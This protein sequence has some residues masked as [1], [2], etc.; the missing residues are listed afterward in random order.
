M[1]GTLHNNEVVCSLAWLR[2]KVC[3]LWER[4]WTFGF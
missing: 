3:R 2:W 4:G 1:A